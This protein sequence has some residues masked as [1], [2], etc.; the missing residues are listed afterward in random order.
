MLKSRTGT[1]RSDQTT[2]WARTAVADALLTENRVVTP[3]GL[4]RST[5]KYGSNRVAAG[6]S[7]IVQISAVAGPVVRTKQND[8]NRSCLPSMG[9][10]PD[11]NPL[12]TAP[13]PVFISTEFILNLFYYVNGAA[14]KRR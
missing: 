5:S 4:S 7:S 8:A 11:L 10:P 9:G 14:Q 2:T 3:F 12:T 6:T 1:E 13:A